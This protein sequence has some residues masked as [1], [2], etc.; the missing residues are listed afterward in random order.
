[1]IAQSCLDMGLDN[2]P[3]IWDHFAVALALELYEGP[4][5]LCQ[6]CSPR[7]AVYGYSEWVHKDDT[8]LVTELFQVIYWL[9]FPSSN[10]I[11]FLRR[12][13]V[14]NMSWFAVS[15]WNQTGLFTMG[16]IFAEGRSRKHSKKNTQWPFS[17]V[18]LMLRTWAVFY[19]NK[20]VGGAL[21]TMLVALVCIS[22]T[23]NVKYQRS[24]IC[25]YVRAELMSYI[26]ERSRRHPALPWVSGMFHYRCIK[27][28]GSGFY[29]FG[30]RGH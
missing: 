12:K 4:F 24:L 11:G 10:V 19:Q 28:F 23:A 21:A 15:H 25:E 17:T 1:M 14:C 7:C 30:C 8:Q 29:C 22:F 3:E 5:L 27:H 26:T 16:V 2:K 20:W 9:G 13:Y 18:V 6:I